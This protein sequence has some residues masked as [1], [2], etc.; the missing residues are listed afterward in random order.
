MDA[1]LA[2]VAGAEILAE[3]Q[4]PTRVSTSTPPSIGAL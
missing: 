4:H 1:V 2:A 3:H